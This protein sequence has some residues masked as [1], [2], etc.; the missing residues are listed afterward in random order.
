MLGRA[1]LAFLIFGGFPFIEA[2]HALGVR[3]PFGGNAPA[4]AA[5]ALQA[6]LVMTAVFIG[7]ALIVEA[8]YRLW[9]RRP[10]HSP[11]MNG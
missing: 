1:A 4:F 8:L 6:H 11:A 7:M 3:V 5:Y 9:R 2:F 10:R